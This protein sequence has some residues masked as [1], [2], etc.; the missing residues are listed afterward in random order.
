MRTSCPP[1]ACAETELADGREARHLCAPVFA[2][3]A[4][5]IAPFTLLI[6]NHDWFF[7]PVGYIDPWT[8]LGFFDFYANPHYLPHLYKLARLPWILSGWLI[9]HLFSPLA[10]AY[11]LHGAFLALAVGAMFATA[12]LALDD[13][14]VAFATALILGFLTSFHGSGGWE[15]HNTGAGTFYLVSTALLQWAIAAPRWRGRA[16]AAWGAAFALTIH[17]NITFIN[18]L[19]VLVIHYCA[20][21]GY[22]EGRARGATTYLLPF[23]YAAAAA[24]GITA[25]LSAINVA[26]GRGPWFFLPLLEITLRYVSNAKFQA[27]WWLP[28]SAGWLKPPFAYLAVP[29]ATAIA[30]AIVL[31]FE[32][33]CSSARRLVALLFISEQVF[34]VLLWVLW[35]TLGQT[36]LSPDYFAFPLIPPSVLAIAGILFLGTPR[37]QGMPRLPIALIGGAFLS[38][39]LALINEGAI[40]RQLPGMAY[41]WLLVPTGLILAGLLLYRGLPS[42]R[43]AWLIFFA[44]FAVANAAIPYRIP[45][46]YRADGRCRLRPALYETIVNTTTA[47][48]AVDPG[49]AK[50][51]LWFDEK[52]LMKPLPGCN[53]AMPSVAYSIGGVVW[54]YLTRP[55]PVP[56]VDRI[57]EEDLVAAGQNGFLVVVPTNRPQTIAHL[58]TRFAGAGVAITSIERAAVGAAPIKLDLYL[59]QTGRH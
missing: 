29:A 9:F 10:A 42:G 48:A 56:P 44:L 57:P 20:S 30:G 31:A 36:A 22:A 38:V 2:G 45:S 52:E 47:L 53:I 46:P 13:L 43:A 24:I 17:S 16:M 18:L 8:Y 28:W 4:A 54:D 50:A 5:A 27:A 32:R 59:L 25:L 7:T 1:S 40:V 58:E 14:L 12:W 6:W 55:F 51:R 11:I 49:L 35:Q 19:P 41:T 21:I 15:Y 23:F 39:A 34:L 33:T 3:L 26:V 37:P